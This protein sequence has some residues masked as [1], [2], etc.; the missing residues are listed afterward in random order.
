[1][2]HFSEPGFGLSSRGFRQLG[3]GHGGY[4]GRLLGTLV[5]SARARAVELEAASETEKVSA[6]GGSRGRVVGYVLS[7]G[8]RLAASGVLGGLAL[9]LAGGRLIQ[10]LLFDVPATDPTSFAAVTALFALVSLVAS[11][12]P[13]RRA[14]RVDP[15]VVLSDR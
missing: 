12:L 15:V 6:L 8:A 2:L 13:A 5:R 11:Y 9:A 14:C 10:G 3:R 1:M 4:S 7:Q